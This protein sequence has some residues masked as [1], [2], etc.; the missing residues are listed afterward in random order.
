V[1]AFNKA[2][3]CSNER[4]SLSCMP[5]EARM[6]KFMAFPLSHE[7]YNFIKGVFNM[8]FE[9]IATQ[10]YPYMYSIKSLQAES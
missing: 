8:K 5:F 7:L 2:Y 10:M 9:S 3:H 4:K 1:V 6:T